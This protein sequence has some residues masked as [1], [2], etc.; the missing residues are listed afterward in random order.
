MPCYSGRVLQQCKLYFNILISQTHPYPTSAPTRCVSLLSALLPDKEAEYQM[1]H[2]KVYFKTGILELLEEQRGVALA[3]QAIRIQKQVRRYQQLRRYRKCYY[4][5][6]MGRGAEFDT[7]GH[8]PTNSNHVLTQ[9]P[10]TTP[11]RQVSRSAACSS[12]RRFSVVRTPNGYST[13]QSPISSRR[14]ALCSPASSW[15][16]TG[17]NAAPVRAAARHATCGLRC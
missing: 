15:R 7:G 1:G 10:L 11:T 14:R 6:Q 13:R 3:S 2:T 4:A 16:S 12:C 9:T 5:I 8:R 17:R